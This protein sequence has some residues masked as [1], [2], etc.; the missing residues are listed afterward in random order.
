MKTPEGHG[1]S[2]IEFEYY[3]HA[4][5]KKGIYYYFYVKWNHPKIWIFTKSGDSY[6]TVLP[7]LFWFLKVRN[8]WS[9]LFLTS[10]VNTGW[11]LWHVFSWWLIR[12]HEGWCVFN[13][14]KKPQ[15]KGEYCAHFKWA[16][17]CGNSWTNDYRDTSHI[18]L[19]FW[20]TVVTSVPLT[21][22][23]QSPYCT[24]NEKIPPPLYSN[25]FP[26]L[27]NREKKFEKKKKIYEMVLLS[28]L[29]N[30]CLCL[31]N[32]LVRKVFRD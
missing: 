24:S 27:F 14:P 7:E 16:Q 19:H 21:W 17:R 15:K 25:P 28:K 18:C 11:V 9:L 1:K 8:F 31:E 3:G 29:S 2:R 4:W 20:L 26:P 32:W 6:L 5:Q 12:C 22:K 23:C 13:P 30:V 10:C